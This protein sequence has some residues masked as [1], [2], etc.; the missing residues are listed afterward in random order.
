MSSSITI[1][2]TITITVTFTITV[3]ITITITVTVCRYSSEGGHPHA[4]EDQSGACET[5]RAQVLSQQPIG[6]QSTVPVR[7]G[8]CC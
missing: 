6:E 1:T 5:S 2:I 3:T 7:Y 8:E 4:S